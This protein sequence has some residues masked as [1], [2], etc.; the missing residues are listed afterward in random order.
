MTNQHTYLYELK[1]YS[2]VRTY[3]PW[4]DGQLLAGVAFKIC[5][6]TYWPWNDGQL[7]AGVAFKIW[8]W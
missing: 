6:L 3:W 7:L 2:C 1:H 8:Q 5:V 4:N